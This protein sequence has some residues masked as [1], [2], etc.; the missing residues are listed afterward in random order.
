MIENLFVVNAQL[1]KWIHSQ[2][3]VAN[4]SIDLTLHESVK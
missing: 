4:V 1:R 2:K 3:N